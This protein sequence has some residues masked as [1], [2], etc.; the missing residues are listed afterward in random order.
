[1]TVDT[2]VES[3]LLSQLGRSFSIFHPILL[4][5]CLSAPQR[6]QNEQFYVKLCLLGLNDSEMADSE[7]QATALG[8]E[9]MHFGPNDIFIAVMGMT[10]AGKSTF[11]SQC[12]ESTNVKLEHSLQIRK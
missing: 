2:G 8:L 4:T 12:T 10:G 5:I 6:S 9:H 7:A 1:M 3:N 11:I